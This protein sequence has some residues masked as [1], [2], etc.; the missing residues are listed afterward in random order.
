MPYPWE[1]EKTRLKQFMTEY[2]EKDSIEAVIEYDDG[3]ELGEEDNFQRIWI[4]IQNKKF[5]PWK[6]LLHEGNLSILEK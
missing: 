4:V 2:L 6:K 3:D 5:R 1:Q